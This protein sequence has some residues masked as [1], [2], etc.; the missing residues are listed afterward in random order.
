MKYA[1][2]KIIFQFSLFCAVIITT[3]TAYAQQETV[4]YEHLSVKNGLSSNRVNSIIQDRQGFYW[5]STID[6]LNRFD[7]SAVKIFRHNRNDSASISNNNCTNLLEGNE[8]DI[9]IAT[10]RGVCRYIKKLGRFKN[11]FFRHPAVNDNLVNS[12]SGL[13]KDNKGNIWVSSYGLWRINPSTD[14]ITGFLYQPVV[15]KKDPGVPEISGVVYDKINNGLWAGT[16]RGLI[17]FDL[18][19]KQYFNHANYPY[20]WQG[21]LSADKHFFLQPMMRLYGYTIRT[22]KNYFV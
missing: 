14:S 3:T 2:S 22:K 16:A 8:G 13:T 17:F 12:I 15:N 1:F 9:W 11:Y 18:K 5:I 6:G 10:T 21:F 4:Y 20:Q 19:T 7:G